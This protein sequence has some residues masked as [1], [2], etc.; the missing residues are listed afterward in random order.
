MD[1]D[2]HSYI[3]ETMMANIDM[4]RIDFIRK[5]P[6]QGT[7]EF[8]F[9]FGNIIPNVGFISDVGE[10][11]WNRLRKHLQRSFPNFKETWSKDFIKSSYRL[12]INETTYETKLQQ[13]NKLLV[14]NIPV[15][16]KEGVKIG[17]AHV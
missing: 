17:R 5:Q 12:N 4:K 1:K 15:K 6:D 13:K 7:Y 14:Q 16:P 10:D 9:R 2:L 11:D 3:Y 8:E